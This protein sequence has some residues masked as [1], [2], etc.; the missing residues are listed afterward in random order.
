MRSDGEAVCVCV[1]T[2]IGTFRFLG[3]LRIEREGGFVFVSCEGLSVVR[4][5][6]DADVAEG[7]LRVR[8]N[9]V[10]ISNS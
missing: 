8:F 10:S 3:L 5:G 2:F 6:W 4:F 7:L 9:C 1:C